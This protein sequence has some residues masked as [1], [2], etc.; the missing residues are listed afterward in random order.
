MIP[1]HIRWMISR[2]LPQVLAIEVSRFANPLTEREFSAL[3]HEQQIIA[4]VA[5]RDEEIVGFMI[6]RLCSGRLI[7]L[8]IAVR[9][10]L[11]LNGIGTQM[12]KKLRAKLSVGRRTHV[13]IVSTGGR[14]HI[15][16]DIR[17]T[18]LGGQLFLASCGFKATKIDRKAFQ[19][20]GESSYR[21]IL[22]LFCDEKGMPEIIANRNLRNDPNF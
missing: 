15:D 3:L 5:E 20:T 14:T 17:E 19:D 16:I 8:Q 7:L 18:N 11:I 13:D 2:D 6:Y 12:V 22:S 9:E 10:D 4:M 21:M 1:V